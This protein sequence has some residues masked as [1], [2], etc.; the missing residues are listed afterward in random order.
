MTV[1]E[2]TRIDPETGAVLVRGVRTVTLTYKS[3][4][5]TIELPGWYPEDDQTADQ[6][7]HTPKDMLVS[8]R[9]INA[10]RAR[11][12]GLMTADEIRTT[13]KKLKLTQRE[14]AEIIGGGPN[15]FQKYEAGDVILSKAAD[16]LLRLLA[17]NPARLSELARSGMTGR[18]RRRRTRAEPI[19][20]RRA[21]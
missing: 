6:G 1:A 20:A 16:N 17:V 15:A 19:S 11:E 18:I 14:A 10:M 7:L 21:G 3:Q 2:E 13:R 5:E 4:S 9:A 12:A 8:D